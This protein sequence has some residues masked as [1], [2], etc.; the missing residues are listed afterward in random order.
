M[1]RVCMNARDRTR[2]RHDV[3]TVLNRKSA[4][5]G[6]KARM[7]STISGGSRGQRWGCKVARCSGGGGGAGA[8]VFMVWQR[9]E[10]EEDDDDDEEED[11]DDDDDDDDDN[12]KASS[13]T[14]MLAMVLLFLLMLL[15][16]A[17]LLFKQIPF[18]LST[19]RREDG[20]WK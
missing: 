13:F 10:E 8:G 16:S 6:R 1:I 19:T 9:I 12:E 4:W 20:Y 5:M 7:C 14:T 18:S 11:F 2:A 15:I 3:H 17:V